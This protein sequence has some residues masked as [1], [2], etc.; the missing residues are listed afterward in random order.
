MP[1]T[2]IFTDPL[3][4][5]PDAVESKVGDETVILHLKSGTYFGLDPMGTRIW[6]MLKESVAPAAICARLCEEFDVAA[7]VAEADVR[8][9]L[10]EMK[11]NH[12]LVEG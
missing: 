10:G 5:S 1:M 7:D 2:D 12:I 9:F 11:A 8:R 4:P 3:T 6:A